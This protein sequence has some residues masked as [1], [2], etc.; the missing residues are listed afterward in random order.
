MSFDDPGTKAAWVNSLLQCCYQSKIA[1]E[2]ASRYVRPV[3]LLEVMG[4]S[5]AQVL[6]YE[7]LMGYWAQYSTTQP[8]PR[9]LGTLVVGLLGKL[10]ILTAE[11]QRTVLAEVSAIFESHLCHPVTHEQIM[12]V[13]DLMQWIYRKH[14]IEPKLR[15]LYQDGL[16][17]KDLDVLHRELTELKGSSEVDRAPVDPLGIANDTKLPPTFSSGLAWFDQ[18]I[19]GGFMP[20]E[21]YS[22]I[23]PTGGGK[24]T[25]ATLLAVSLAMQGYKVMM[26]LTEQSF[27]E[28]RVRAKFWGVITGVPYE[29]FLQ[30]KSEEEIPKEILSPEI[31]EKVGRIRKNILCYDKSHVTA[32]QHVV[33]LARRHRPHVLF[34][35]W[36]GTLANVIMENPKDPLSKDRHLCLRK[37]ADVMNDIAKELT[38]CP[39]VFHQLNPLCSNP[40][41]EKIS[42]KDAME[43]KSFS[44]NI[45][46]ALV[47]WPKDK[48]DIMK[49]KATKSRYEGSDGAIV[50][51][52]GAKAT[53]VPMVSYRKGRGAWVSAKTPE[54]GEIPNV[55]KKK[56]EGFG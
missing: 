50:R 22:C 20:G 13:Q 16:D 45:S 24:S 11:G 42:H 51:L 12:P 38:I 23:G 32:V 4:A 35:D 44:T 18:I 26:I 53:F 34:L 55:N 6:I 37:I 1:M 41:D 31:R 5:K 19:G 17:G 36:A 46:Y 49:I 9:I 21:A 48:N 33:G 30:Y 43:C 28:A 14:E 2:S 7:A 25:L 47:M 3:A 27:S 40:F 39:F 8:E 56:E 54:L 15:D 29:S 10:A 52:D